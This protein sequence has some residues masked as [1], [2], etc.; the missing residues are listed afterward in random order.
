MISCP[1]GSSHRLACGAPRAGLHGYR[2]EVVPQGKPERREPGVGTPTPL[3]TWTAAIHGL[4]A[5]RDR[6]RRAVV[7]TTEVAREALWRNARPGS[8]AS[9]AGSCARRIGTEPIQPPGS[10]SVA[11]PAATGKSRAEGTAALG[12]RSPPPQCHYGSTAN[13]GSSTLHQR[14]ATP[15]RSILRHR[16]TSP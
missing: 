6:P 14:A 2:V 10:P 7:H 13:T 9:I 11:S 8:A 5:E 4:L 1:R 16:G 15:D 3:D 12:W